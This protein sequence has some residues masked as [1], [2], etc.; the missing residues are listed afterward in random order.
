LDYY[1]Q[2][3]LLQQTQKVLTQLFFFEI[4]DNQEN[5]ITCAAYEP[6]KQFRRIIRNL[7][8]GD[9]IEVYGGVRTKPLTINLEKIKIIKLTRIFE[10]EENPICPNCG[11]H[12][13][14]VGANQGYKCK[15]CGKKSNETVKKE[16]I[17]SI[18]TGFYEVP[19]CARRHLSKPLKRMKIGKCESV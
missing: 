1:L 13:K 5:T 15:I 16:I 12:M 10:K 18:E 4:C 6:T 11:K 19:V 2:F 8:F 9:V 3:L 17:R 7:R 14:S